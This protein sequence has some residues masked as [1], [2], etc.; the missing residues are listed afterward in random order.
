MPDTD[1]RNK[2]QNRIKLLEI[3]LEQARSSPATISSKTIHDLNGTLAVAQGQAH[4]A[5]LNI[6]ANSKALVNVEEICKAV[7]KALIIVDQLY[8]NIQKLNA[9][10]TT[11]TSTSPHDRDWHGK[12]TILFVD[13]EENMRSMINGVLKHY[14]YQ[15]LLANDGDQALELFKKSHE[16]IHLVFMDMTMPRVNGLEAF[17]LMRQIDPTIPIVMTSGY[18]EV[19]L[20]EKWPELGMNGFLRKPC[21]LQTLLLTIKQ[22][23]RS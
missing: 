5:L 11:P 7:Q 18:S 3:Q 8:E 12:G 13:D 9:H 16:D 20:A 2:L 10:S 15:V 4:M 19:T 22:C 6:S 23:I 21:D 17:T 1:L 14:G